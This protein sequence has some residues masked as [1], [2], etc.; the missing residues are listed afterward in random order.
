MVAPPPLLSKW[1]SFFWKRYLGLGQ[2][3]NLGQIKNNWDKQTLN[4]NIFV[5]SAFKYLVSE[6]AAVQKPSIVIHNWSPPCKLGTEE[7]LYNI[8]LFTAFNP[9]Q[10]GISESLIRPRGFKW[11]IQKINDIY[12]CSIVPVYKIKFVRCVSVEKQ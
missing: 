1:R 5:E 4:F 10:A 8:V 3:G 2:N 12:F 6:K 9:H 11:S 7:W